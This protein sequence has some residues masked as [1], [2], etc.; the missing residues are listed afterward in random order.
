MRAPRLT[1]ELVERYTRPTLW[2]DRLIDD[3]L[4][5]AARRF[6]D[7]LAVVDRGRSWTFREVDD[8][9]S[10]VASMLRELGVQRGEAVSWQLPNW[11][12]G[13]VL[14]QAALRIGAVSNPIVA[15]YREREVSFILQQA[16]S[17][18]FFVPASFRTFDY[19]DMAQKL[20]PDLP[21]LGDVIVVGGERDGV[22]SFDA[23]MERAV[24]S[25][26]EPDRSANDVV[27]LLYTS[28]T[29]SAPKGALHTHNTLD[30][31]NRS[32]I[33]LF[34]L[35]QSDV[36]FMPSPITHITGLLYGMQLPFMLGSTVVLQDIWDADEAVALIEQYRCTFC[37]GA[38]PFLHGVLNRSGAGT[39][40]PLRVFACGGAD[41]PPDLI[42]KATDRLGTFVTRV[43]GSTEFPTAMSS[44]PRDPLEKRATT[45]GRRIAA[46]E[47]RIVALDG[48]EA[49]PGVEGELQVRGPEL[50]LGY[51]DEEL[52]TD[53]FTPDGWFHTGD[54]AVADAE[55]F[56]S[57][58]GRIKDIIIRGGEN[59]SA[60]EVEDLIFEH[61]KVAEVSVV[62]YPDPVMVERICAVVVPEDGA[63][64]ELPELVAFLKSHGIANQKLPE[65]LV[66]VDQLPK[67]ASGKIQKFRLRDRLTE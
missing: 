51:L 57:I 58:T 26:P 55:G 27:L 1:R 16:R 13:I 47:V 54:V 12:E 53:S 9:V 41:V 60:K 42:R 29:T 22:L 25:T 62:G 19:V 2:E 32:I 21:D 52:N 14:H 56:L 44:G 46:A 11:L 28:G 45:D 5:E 40:S 48:E 50:F 7:D 8:A 64:L 6:P 23:L 30:Y 33:D 61:P 20:L 36:I 39:A 63:E 10:R 37:V 3:H 65:R 15:I 34:E 59:I 24:P 38:T 31:E 66:L 49:P 17:R 67:T 43:Y 18:L 4:T 35:G